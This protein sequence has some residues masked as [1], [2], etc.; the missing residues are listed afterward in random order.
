MCQDYTMQNESLVV[1]G[2]NKTLHIWYFDYADDLSGFSV[3][4]L[5][6]RKGNYQLWKPVGSQ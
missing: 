2:K 4:I 1:L 3:E 5:I 6:K